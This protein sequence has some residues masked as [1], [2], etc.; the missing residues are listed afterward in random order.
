MLE[1]VS[2]V[3]KR[4]AVAV[5]REVRW[6]PVENDADVVL[7]QVVH[8]VHEILRSAVARR[9]CEVAG[10]LISPGAIERMLHNREKLNMSEAQLGDVLC[11]P[12]RH[13]AVGE[14]AVVLFRHAHPGAEV[15][16]VH[17]H[18]SVE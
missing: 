5:G 9:R 4:K 1:Q 13:F 8:E 16:L 17:R 15:D 12:G 11:Q 18:G 2:A 6:N 7:V 10:G 3:E 14:R